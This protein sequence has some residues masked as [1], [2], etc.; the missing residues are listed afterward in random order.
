MLFTKYLAT[1]NMN[2]GVPKMDN[3]LFSITMN[4]VALEARI[5]ELKKVQSDFEGT[6]YHDKIGLRI[7]DLQAKVDKLSGKKHPSH[8]Y[9]TTMK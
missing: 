1:A 4:I 2:W 9:S 6:P 8:V 3:N 7:S 5:A